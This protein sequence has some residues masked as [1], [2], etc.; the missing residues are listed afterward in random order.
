[1]VLD[2]GLCLAVDP[3]VHPPVGAVGLTATLLPL[4]SIKQRNVYIHLFT[5]LGMD[6][7]YC[8]LSTTGTAEQAYTQYWVSRASAGCRSRP[9]P[10]GVC[11]QLYCTVVVGA[12]FLAGVTTSPGMNSGVDI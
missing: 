2:L 7:Q 6:E 8:L 9:G 5:T 1:M 12:R 4:L 3:L 10:R 11:V